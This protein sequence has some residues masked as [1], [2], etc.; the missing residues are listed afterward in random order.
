VQ[1][2]CDRPTAAQLLDHQWIK[3]AKKKSFLAESLLGMPF[4]CS[5]AVASLTL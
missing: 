3:G 1:R 4:S 5:I 2:S